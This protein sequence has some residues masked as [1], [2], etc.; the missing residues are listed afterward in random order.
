M[1]D[2]T[3]RCR[4]VGQTSFIRIKQGR[5]A[6]NFRN[7][8]L[9][10]CIVVLALL[11]T[12]LA[13]FTMDVNETDEQVLSYRQITDITGQFSHSLAPYYL[14]YTPAENYTGY[15]YDTFDFV[16]SGTA[17]P[18]RVTT[19]QGSTTTQTVDLTTLTNVTT[20]SDTYMAKKMWNPT[21]ISVKDM[22]TELGIDYHDYDTVRIDLYSP[23]TTWRPYLSNTYC[24]VAENWVQTGP[25]AP[26]NNNTYD[27]SYY[28]HTSEANGS[29]LHTVRG[30]AVSKYTSTGFGEPIFNVS[31]E[32]MDTS[33][34]A[35]WLE[36]LSDSTVVC[37]ES[38]NGVTNVAYSID[39]SS[40]MIDWSDILTDTI[41]TSAVSPYGTA[42]RDYLYKDSTISTANYLYDWQPTHEVTITLTANSSYSYMNISEGV[43]LKTGEDTT[44]WRNTHTNGD[45][46]ILFKLDNLTGYDFTVACAGASVNVTTNGS[47]VLINGRDMGAW[48][49]FLLSFNAQSGNIGFQPVTSFSNFQVYTAA[50]QTNIT[51]TSMN[52]DST[53]SF[54]VTR[55]TGTPT[56]RWSVTSTTVWLNTYNVVM[57]DPSIDLRAY[58]P[59]SEQPVLRLNFNSFSVI[60]DSITINNVT[61]PVTNGAITVDGEVLPIRG[62]NVTWDSTT[63]TTSLESGNVT[64]DLGATDTTTV[65]MSGVW[66]FISYAY[67]GFLDTEK[68]LDWNVG[69]WIATF[70]QCIVIFLAL[71]VAGLLVGRRTG[72]VGSLD[73]IVVIFAGLIGLLVVV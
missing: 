73:Y 53:D 21:Y 37:Y 12:V 15:T 54:T 65:S 9:G 44:T 2:P 61:Y 18:Y 31:I 13:G 43:G 70:E 72:K 56:P 8:L 62:L 36:V 40:A 10:T 58:F 3:S 19:V 52:A 55:T 60:G 14:D 17:N 69:H 11:G 47:S 34:Y 20:P 16:A 57:V 39:Y 41:R 64:V 49:S 67:G 28:L 33:T 42:Y 30:N 7:G 63:N 22:L 1:T 6:M 51:S 29:V 50:S 45:I 35:L 38:K 68:V 27:G 48:T 26:Q 71:L 5:I 23:D 66:Y 25:N 4:G 59:D 46:G 24:H 32:N